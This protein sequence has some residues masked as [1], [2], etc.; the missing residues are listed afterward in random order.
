M[1]KSAERLWEVAMLTKNRSAA[2]RIRNASLL[3]IASSALL[4]PMQSDAQPPP[5]PPEPNQSSSPGTPSE[6]NI[7]L[8]CHNGTAYFGYTL[9]FATKRFTMGQGEQGAITEVTVQIVKMVPDEYHGVN[10]Y[11]YDRQRHQVTRVSYA[12]AV[13]VVYELDICVESAL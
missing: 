11:T 7:A 4:A 6:E 9:N 2:H 12:T 1:L 3:L 13:P 10:V 5:P 8:W